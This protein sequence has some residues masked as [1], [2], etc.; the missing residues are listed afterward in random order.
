MKTEVPGLKK[1]GE[2]IQVNSYISMSKRGRQVGRKTKIHILEILSYLCCLL[3]NGPFWQKHRIHFMDFME[4]PQ[5][6]SSFSS[7]AL[8][9]LGVQEYG[10]A[11]GGC[12]KTHAS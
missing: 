10:K 9:L 6:P 4:V 7:P 11:Q 1:T 8:R 5:C 2:N 12:T 3:P